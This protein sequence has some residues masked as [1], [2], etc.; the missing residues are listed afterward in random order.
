MNHVN[1]IFKWAGG[2][3]RMQEKYALVFF[4]HKPFTQFV[5]LFFGAGSVTTW[6]ANAYPNVPLLINDINTELI[7]LYRV[8]ATDYDALEKAFLVLVDEFLSYPA[9]PLPVTKETSFLDF[10]DIP[11]PKIPLGRK[12]FYKR[13]LDRYAFHYESETAVVN[14]ALLLFMLKTS[15]NG[16][17]KAYHKYNGRFSTPPGVLTQDKTFFDY[18]EI[19]AFALMLSRAQIESMSYEAIRPQKGSFIYADP[20]Y[21]SSIIEYQSTFTDIHQQ[22]LIRYLLSYAQDGCYIAESNRDIGD[23][24]WQKSFP[25]CRVH[26]FD[27]IY[28]AGRGTSTIPAEEV[29]VTNY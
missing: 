15:F 18:R 13:C 4:P 7:A 12:A 2:K 25:T 6:V 9:P 29:L 22:A 20:P 16:M 17:W 27:V 24:F 8:M 21:R 19:R 28:T 1:P 5:D 14:A 10:S 26:V 23:G 3:S 11:T